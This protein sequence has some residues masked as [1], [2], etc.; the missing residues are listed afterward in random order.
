M[1]PKVML[2]VIFPQASTL[3]PPRQQIF[4][5]INFF[6]LAT[7]AHCSTLT[8]TCSWALSQAVFCPPWVLWQFIKR[9]ELWALDAVQ[10]HVYSCAEIYALCSEK[11]FKSSSPGGTSLALDAWGIKCPCANQLITGPKGAVM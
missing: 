6:P 7:E 1:P 5:F 3:Q 8:L 4:P 9:A 11:T 10:Y 2:Q